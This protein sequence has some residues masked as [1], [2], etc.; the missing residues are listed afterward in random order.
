MLFAM[1]KAKCAWLGAA[2]LTR[3]TIRFTMASYLCPVFAPA[4]IVIV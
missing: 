4:A 3:T 2:I 1:E